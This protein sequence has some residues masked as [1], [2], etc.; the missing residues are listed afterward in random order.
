MKSKRNILFVSS[1]YPS[2]YQPTLG[3][4]IQR[5][6]EAVATMHHVTVLH[7][8]YGENMQENTFN[9]ETREDHL[10]REILIYYGR[11]Q[12]FLPPLRKIKNY[13]NLR[14]AYLE[15]LKKA[16]ELSKNFDLIHLNIPWPIGLIGRKISKKLNIPY[17]VSEHWTGYHPSDGRYRGW[18]MKFITKK[19]IS[20]AKFVV[21][22]SDFVSRVMMKHG[23]R[24]NFISVPNVVDI[25]MF[26]PEKN[27][28]LNNMF[29]HVSSL[30]DPQKNVSGLIRAF[31]EAQKME[32]EIRLNIVGSGR[33][34]EVLH[35]LVGQLGLE[36]N[37]FFSGL[38]KGREL[39]NI[40]RQSTAL[41]LFS[42]Y[43][44]QPVVILEALCS[45]IPVI[46]TNV[47]SIPELIS[48]ERGI[49]ISP[50]DEKGLIQAIIKMHKERVTYDSESI[51][52]FAVK[53]F[54][55][56]VIAEK[57]D[58]IYQKVLSA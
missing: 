10:V 6:A 52:G 58:S 36:K 15:G 54:S 7:A 18:L 3:I 2:K 22:E 48:Q 11:S 31:A 42:R 14:K 25:E 26:S 20:D 29:I 41:I 9:I 43:E 21:T 57:L 45:G 24:G 30:D 55:K 19:T 4:F 37:V 33:N 35:Q 38:K 17:L 27:L 5:K 34:D 13:L 50:E 49:L 32:P 40:F 51:R 28:P 23:I 44:N 12:S 1:W 46:S 16:I 53:Q 56:Q 39:A 47:G 8:C